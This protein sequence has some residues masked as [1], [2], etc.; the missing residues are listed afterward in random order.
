MRALLLSC[1][2]TTL[3]FA[4]CSKDPVDPPDPAMCTANLETVASGVTL[5]NPDRDPSGCHEIANPAGDP[6]TVCERKTPD[7]AC[8]GRQ[9]SRGVSVNV[10][11][12]GCVTTFGLGADSDDLTVTVLRERV[13]D[14]A[15]DPGYDVLGMP[16]MQDEHTPGA[17]IGRAIST[18]VPVAQCPDTG[19]YEI[20]N[21]PTETDLIV[22][23]TDQNLEES[24]RQKVDTYQYNFRLRNDSLVDMNGSAVADPASCANTPCF[25]SEEVNTIAIATFRTIPR[26]AGVS[27]IRGESNLFDGDGEGHIAGEVQD[28]TS[29]DKVQNAIVGVSADARKVT[30]FNAGFDSSDGP[31][32]LD[33]PKPLQTRPRTNGD[34]LY[35]A[36]GVE[37]AQGGE[38]VT[39]AAAIKGTECGDDMICKCNADGTTNPAWSAP[40]ANEGARILGSRT[41]YVFPDSITIM[42]FDRGM[43]ETPM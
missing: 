18:E 23:V 2:S 13:N 11:L 30:Y 43:Y 28:C 29:E 24:L 4:A 38:P 7:F 15:V 37:T 9:V 22:R 25:V 20:A 10:T 39:V 40:D 14:M 27:V 17:V 6:M 12:R 36:I 26:A 35:A 19:F 5:K 3:L 34:G 31:G 32:T 21:V 1:A 33:D 16:G 41:V 8:V 42:T